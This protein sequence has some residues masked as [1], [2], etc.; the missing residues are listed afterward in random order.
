M[1]WAGHIVQTSINNVNSEV[2]YSATAETSFNDTR[3]RRLANKITGSSTIGLSDM[4]FGLQLPQIGY[5]FDF[6]ANTV[7]LAATDVGA[8]FAIAYVGVQLSSNGVGQYYSYQETRIPQF[9]IE[10]S[11][12]WLTSGSAGDY[13]GQYLKISGDS[14]SGTINT[15]LALSTSRAWQFEIAN[16]SP[17]STLETGG[18]G[19]IIIKRSGVIG[20]YRKF[21]FLV[22]GTAL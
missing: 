18:E 22:T 19:T 15:D 16:F 4:R 5:T 10:K 3:V 8:G 7:Y 9:I 20:P 17:G 1:S 12:T 6:Y 2:G 11:F 13:T 21:E 14:P